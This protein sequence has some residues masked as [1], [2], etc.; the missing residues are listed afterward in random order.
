MYVKK[1]NFYFEENGIKKGKQL[2]V[3]LNSIRVWTC[4]PITLLEYKLY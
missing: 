1:A 3:S 4:E 2:V